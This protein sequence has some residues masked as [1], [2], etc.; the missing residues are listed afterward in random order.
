MRRNLQILIKDIGKQGGLVYLFPIVFA[1][2]QLP[3]SVEPI[4]Q[5]PWG[6]HQ[7]KAL[8]KGTV[9]DRNNLQITINIKKNTLQSKYVPF[10]S[11]KKN[12]MI[13]TQKRLFKISFRGH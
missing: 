7:I 6:F 5:S 9:S 8:I 11:K 2:L 13:L 1:T 4:P 10:F 12:C 3:V